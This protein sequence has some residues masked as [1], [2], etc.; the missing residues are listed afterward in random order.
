MKPVKK[1]NSLFC[2]LF[3]SPPARPQSKD[4]T[5]LQTTVPRAPGS[6]GLQFMI[7][8]CCRPISKLSVLWYWIVV[9]HV[10]SWARRSVCGRNLSSHADPLWD[11]NPPWN[12]LEATCPDASIPGDLGPWS[13]HGDVG[14]WIGPGRRSHGAPDAVR[15][16]PLIIPPCEGDYIK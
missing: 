11:R 8:G 15:I 9:L 5:G 10:K 7:R 4:L 16:C 14:T 2:F 12:R 6:E 13:G 3:P 1:S